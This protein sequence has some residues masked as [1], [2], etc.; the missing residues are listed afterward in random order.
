MRLNECP[1]CLHL[2]PNDAQPGAYPGALSRVD[3]R[4]EVCSDCGTHEAL[5]QMSRLNLT[6]KAQW[7]VAD[8]RAT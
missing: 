8:Y 4:T 1:R 2:I 3:N 7:P 5:Q 6:P